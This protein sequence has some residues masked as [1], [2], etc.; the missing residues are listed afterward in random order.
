MANVVGNDN[1]GLDGTGVLVSKE[2][3]PEALTLTNGRL[4]GLSVSNSNYT[5]AGGNGTVTVTPMAVTPSGTQPSKGTA[6]PSHF[7]VTVN[8]AAPSNSVDITFQNPTSGPLT[9]SFTPPARTASNPN[10]GN[11]APAA[12][13]SGSALFNNN[14][15]AYQSIGQFD[16]NQYSNSRVPDYAAQAGEAT[17]FASIARV[18]DPEHGAD[19]LID[20]FWNGTSG[21]WTPPKTAQLEKL[22]FSDGAGNELDPTGNVGFPIISGS[23]DFA[24][25]LTTGPVM[26]SDRGQPAHWL[27][28]TQ[29]TADGKGIV[30]NDPASA[31]QVV[32]SYDVSTKSVGG[33]TSAF[34]ASSNKFVSFAEASASTPALVGLQRFVPAHFLAVSTK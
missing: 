2:I 32:L 9:I 20:T 6:D 16:P 11:V 30:A 18:A 12:I 3:G 14:G 31:K 21:A 28:A 26:I 34:D 15:L 10:G 4:T 19:Y 22:T 29:M 7:D 24:Q 27:L 8:G 5:V 1:V 17:I 23:T 33:I 25:L 13:S